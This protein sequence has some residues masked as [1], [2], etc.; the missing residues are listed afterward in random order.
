[1]PEVC[2]APVMETPAFVDYQI[3]LT[4][5]TQHLIDEVAP[6]LAALLVR[7]RYRG[8]GDTPAGH[9]AHQPPVPP[10][11]SSPTRKDETCLD[12]AKRQHL[13]VFRRRPGRVRRRCWGQSPPG[14]RCEV[15]V[16]RA[17]LAPAIR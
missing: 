4:V 15:F 7:S 1:M 16:L 12:P 9:S 10:I 2:A 17:A 14:D 8:P 11:G 5:D 3:A 13:C 6:R